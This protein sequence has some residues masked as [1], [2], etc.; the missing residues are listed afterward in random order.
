MGVLVYVYSIHRCT[1]VLYDQT[2]SSMRGFHRVTLSALHCR[3][4]ERGAAP[5]FLPA[6]RVRLAD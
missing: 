3:Q 5:S 6:L 1:Y 4:L 2:D